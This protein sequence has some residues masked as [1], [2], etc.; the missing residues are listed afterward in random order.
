LKPEIRNDIDLEQVMA[1]KNGQFNFDDADLPAVLRQLA[2]WYDLEVVYEGS[3]PKREFGGKIQRDLMLSQVLRILQKMDI[4][5][6]LEGKR[7]LVSSS[8]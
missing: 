1:W 3:I 4:K 7:L 5:F 8:Q 6:T 2:M